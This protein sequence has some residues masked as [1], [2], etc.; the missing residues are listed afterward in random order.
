MQWYAAACCLPWRRARAGYSEYEGAFEHKPA[1]SATVAQHEVQIVNRSRHLELAPDGMLAVNSVHHQSV[2][3]AE[4]YNV[5]AAASD[6][7][8]EAIEAKEGGFAVGVQWHP[9]YCVSQIDDAVWSGFLAAA[10]KY[11]SSIRRPS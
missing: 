4:A 7:V 6:S 2:L 1:Q 9:E 10:S 11:S 5:L 3:P 8:I